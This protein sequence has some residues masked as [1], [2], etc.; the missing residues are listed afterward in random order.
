MC[1]NIICNHIHSLHVLFI[2]RMALNN[3]SR[4]SLTIFRTKFTRES[5]KVSL[6]A[7][8]GTFQ[9]SFFNVECPRKRHTNTW[10][11]FAFQVFNYR[12]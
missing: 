8:Y 6:R 12:T 11:S 9:A 4:R 10:D 5:F 3:F 1:I 2:R 7:T